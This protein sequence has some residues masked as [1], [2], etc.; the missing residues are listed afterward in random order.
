MT[1]P[2]RRILKQ[3]VARGS[4]AIGKRE[5]RAASALVQAKLCYYSPGG[6]NVLHPTEAGKRECER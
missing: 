1:K 2:Q 3:A 4:Y 5:E 6:G